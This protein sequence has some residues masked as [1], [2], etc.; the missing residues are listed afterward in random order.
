MVPEALSLTYLKW[1]VFL[2]NPS[3]LIEPNASFKELEIIPL[4]MKT[5]CGSVSVR[6]LLSSSLEVLFPLTSF[7]LDLSHSHRKEKVSYG[8]S[9][10]LLCE[11]L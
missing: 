11:V 5:V 9:A 10:I 2:M 7:C 3:G 8:T 6:P 1:S 4:V